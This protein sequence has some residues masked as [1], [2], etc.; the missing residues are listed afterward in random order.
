MCTMKKKFY[1]SALRVLMLGVLAMPL[2]SC[3]EDLP[4]DANHEA[5]DLGLSVKW[6]TCNV[7]ANS[8]E[9]FGGYYA[10]GETEVKSTYTWDNYK[11]HGSDDN[12][13][14]IIDE[15]KTPQ[16]GSSISGTSYDVARVKWGDGWRMPTYAEVVELLQKCSWE[17]A[18]MQG[19][20]GKKV[21]GPS[22]GSI[23][24]PA[25]RFREGAGYGSQD[26]FGCYWSGTLRLVPE[27]DGKYL[28]MGFFFEVGL[29]TLSY[30]D[31]QLGLTVRPVKD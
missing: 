6:A 3:E 23:F 14:A 10:W 17:D 1:L 27:E 28:P 7:G 26:G 16:L 30:F 15:T 31:F 20:R 21:V 11:Y 8:P 24:L 19:V 22:G 29:G 13:N 4:E 12:G 2:A 25:T 5:V 18:E 9:E